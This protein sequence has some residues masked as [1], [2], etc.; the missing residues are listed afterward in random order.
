M[1]KEIK[2][3]WIAALRSGE[4]KKGKGALLSNGKYCCLGVLT[5]L[6]CKE[7]GRKWKMDK[8]GYGFI[9]SEDNY[10]PKPV[11][12]WAGLE[13]QNP[14]VKDEALSTW[15]DSLGYG[16]KRIATLIEKGI[17]DE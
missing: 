15:N 3:S 17:P 8:Y 2:E 7:T 16:F 1:K 12:K 9:G 13:S 11:M 14:Y 6:W 10:L 5:N 4:Y